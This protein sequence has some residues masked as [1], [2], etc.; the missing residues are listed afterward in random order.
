MHAA[1]RVLSVDDDPNMRKHLREILTQAGIDV[2]GDRFVEAENGLQGYRELVRLHLAGRPPSL[3]VSDWEMPVMTGID[4]LRRVRT[5]N[6]FKKVPFLLATGVSQQGAVLDAIKAGVTNYV[7]KPYELEGFMGKLS[8]AL[9]KIQDYE[10]V[11]KAEA[12]PPLADRPWLIVDN[13][14]RNRQI[15][16]VMLRELGFVDIVET[17]GANEA[18]ERVTRQRSKGRFYGI[19]CDVN[20]RGTSESGLF[21]YC[22]SRELWDSRGFFVMGNPSEL[23]Q[24]D[25]ALANECIDGQF[26]M[27][28]EKSAL[29]K[30]IG[31]ESP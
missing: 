20:L 27:P 10:L 8:S 4:F 15:F 9:P 26:S 14:A 12:L 1:F 7:V 16:Q 11:L 28:P 17:V 5:D 31:M 30:A 25:R 6:R 22:R 18:M 2:G 21:H 19:L 24:D 13:L 29:A 23:I 3:V